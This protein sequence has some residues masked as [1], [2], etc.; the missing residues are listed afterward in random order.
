[1]LILPTTG[2]TFHLLVH[3]MYFMTVGKHRKAEQYFNADDTF[4]DVC[5]SHVTTM[6]VRRGIGLVLEIRLHMPPRQCRP[7]FSL[8][9][10]LWITF[11][12]HHLRLPHYPSLHT[13]KYV[14]PGSYCLFGVN[15]FF[16]FSFLC[17]IWHV[18]KR[19]G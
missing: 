16:L 8:L 9:P 12:P 15:Y 4:A 7:R 10:F 13:F 6:E 1:M 18:I 11:Y 19:Y 14:S 5:V 17:L 2:L 3:L